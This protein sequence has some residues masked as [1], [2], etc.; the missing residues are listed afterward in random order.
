MKKTL[1]E[2]GNVVRLYQEAEELVRGLASAVGSGFDGTNYSEY[3]DL[4]HELKEA[5]DDL[6]ALATILVDNGIRDNKDITRLLD[7]I[8][9]EENILDNS[10]ENVVH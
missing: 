1:N 8:G 2:L 10:Q 7:R 9:I 5:Q 3:S 6:E 4:Y